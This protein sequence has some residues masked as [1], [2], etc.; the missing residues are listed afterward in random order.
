MEAKKQ[1]NSYL[2]KIKSFP[3][4]K[5]LQS[6]LGYASKASWEWKGGMDKK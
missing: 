3:H 4:L 6:D 1:K 5:C 2:L